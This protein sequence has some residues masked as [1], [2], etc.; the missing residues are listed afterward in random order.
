M[1]VFKQLRIIKLL[2]DL[3]EEKFADYV[4]V[5]RYGFSIVIS[6]KDVEELKEIIKELAEKERF[7]VE[8]EREEV[9]VEV[10]QEQE[11]EY[12]MEI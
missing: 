10:E 6:P 4:N 2:K 11:L 3:A 8:F 7:V 1:D 9:E 12:E 5:E